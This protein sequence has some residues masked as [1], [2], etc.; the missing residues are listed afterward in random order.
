MNYK[1]GYPCVSHE[2]YNTVKI[3]MVYLTSELLH[4]NNEMFWR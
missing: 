1:H 3:D 2:S 4:L